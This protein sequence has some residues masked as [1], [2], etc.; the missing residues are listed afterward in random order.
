V[1]VRPPPS[2]VHCVPAV[3]VLL[4]STFYI[5]NAFTCLVGLD[6][7]WGEIFF[8]P[9]QVC[10]ICIDYCYMYLFRFFGYVVDLT[11]IN[12]SIKTF[13]LVSKG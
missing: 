3:A 11:R 10:R 9:A 4:W 8:F 2:G 12:K 6:G 5:I 1:E 13:K 7:G